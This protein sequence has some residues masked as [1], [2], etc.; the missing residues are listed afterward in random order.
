MACVM[1]HEVLRLV[2]TEKHVLTCFVLYDEQFPCVLF[3]SLT[4]LL[5]QRDAGAQY[6][7]VVRRHR[8]PA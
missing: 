3:I 6:E 1:R 7:G 5:A 2:I 4:D 8:G